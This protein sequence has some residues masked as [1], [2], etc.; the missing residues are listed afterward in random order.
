MSS[1]IGD[2]HSLWTIDAR[3][4]NFKVMVDVASKNSKILYAIK[5]Q[6]FSKFSGISFFSFFI[7]PV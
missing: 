2:L 6:I 5:K 4:K 1:K 7:L 3:S